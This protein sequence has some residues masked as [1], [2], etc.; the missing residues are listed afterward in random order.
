MRALS[1]QRRTRPS[2]HTDL[3]ATAER[4]AAGGGL[5]Q[6]LFAADYD[7]AEGWIDVHEDGELI[8]S[9]RFRDD[10][11]QQEFW[12][13]CSVTALTYREN[14]DHGWLDGRDGR[15]VRAAEAGRR[16]DIPHWLLLP[17]FAPIWGRPG[18]GWQVD[19]NHVELLPTQEL[20]LTLR[21]LDAERADGYADVAWPQTHLR[22]LSLGTELYE[23]REVRFTS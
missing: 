2:A 10:A 7:C 21:S 23:L 5:E 3:I 9:C 16:R 19:L 17:F 1:T 12:S 8:R 15:I 18:D 22:R 11:R 4:L 6:A 20:R 14:A 13:H